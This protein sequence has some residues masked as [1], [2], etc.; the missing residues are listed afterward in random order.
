[1]ADTNLYGDGRRARVQ[2]LPALQRGA[3]P[4]LDAANAP[5]QHLVQR[6]LQPQLLRLAQKYL[7]RQKLIIQPQMT[8]WVVRLPTVGRN[9]YAGM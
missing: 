2:I 7:H 6:A 1:M 9:I 5:Q 3:R 8:Q 4:I